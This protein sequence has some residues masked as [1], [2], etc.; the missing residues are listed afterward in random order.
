MVPTIGSET[1]SVFVNYAVGIPKGG[2]GTRQV[3]NST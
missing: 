3:V 2:Q 1:R